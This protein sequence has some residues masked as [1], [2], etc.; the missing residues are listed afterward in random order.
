MQD[1]LIG[2]VLCTPHHFYTCR[3]VDN[4]GLFVHDT[5]MSPQ[6]VLHG[7]DARGVDLFPIGRLSLEIEIVSTYRIS[8]RLVYYLNVTTSDQCVAA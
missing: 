8:Y 6:E 5:T 3:V 1:L 2:P 4:H 7:N